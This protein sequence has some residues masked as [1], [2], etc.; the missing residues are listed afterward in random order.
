MTESGYYYD[1]VPKKLH[2]KLV[3]NGS[4]YEELRVDPSSP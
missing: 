1:P 2:L 3:S 4:D